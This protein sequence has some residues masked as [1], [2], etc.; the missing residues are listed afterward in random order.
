[1]IILRG[2]CLI[3]ILFLITNPQQRSGP[4]SIINGHITLIIPIGYTLHSLSL[5]RYSLHHLFP[6]GTSLGTPI[7]S[8]PRHITSPPLNM[9]LPQNMRRRNI[10]RSTKNISQLISSMSIHPPEWNV[11]TWSNCFPVSLIFILVPMVPC[12]CCTSLVLSCIAFS[13]PC[14]SILV[15]CLILS[16]SI[17]SML[18]LPT[19]PC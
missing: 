18:T 16:W 13:P 10:I 11:N 7:L 1:M 17:I 8:S 12:A 15:A 6:L 14:T 9:F 5:S 4:Y 3:I 2:L 19:F